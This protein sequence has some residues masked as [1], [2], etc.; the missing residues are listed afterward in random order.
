MIDDAELIR[1][2]VELTRDVERLD[3]I[4]DIQRY[5]LEQRTPNEENA[6]RHWKQIR[7]G[8]GRITTRTQEILDEIAQPNPHGRY[9]PGYARSGASIGARWTSVSPTNRS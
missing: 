5:L 7:A 9:A 6:K 1:E 4:L 3:S 8:L 2:V